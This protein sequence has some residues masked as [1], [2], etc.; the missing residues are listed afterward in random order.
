LKVNWLS[1]REIRK[2]NLFKSTFNLR[3]AAS[4]KKSARLQMGIL[5]GERKPKVYRQRARKREMLGEA[6]VN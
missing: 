6:H 2:V 5:G 3:V 4:C 1:L